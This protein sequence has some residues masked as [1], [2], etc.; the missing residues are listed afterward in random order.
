[1][2][3]SFGVAGTSASASEVAIRSAEPADAPDIAR[4]HIES[5]EHAYAPL[6]GAWP[7]VDVGKRTERWR[8]YLASEAG[9]GRCA[10]VASIG[11]GVVGFIQAGPARRADAGAAVEVFVIHVLPV[12]RGQG[13][14]NAL[15]QAACSS[16][17]GPEL[18]SM[19]VDTLAELPCCAFYEAHGGL[20]TEQRPIEYH[21]AARTH[22]TYVW[23]K[24]H[25]H[26][27]SP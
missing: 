23:P 13:V 9:P 20:R 15:W 26:G 1:L 18:M 14:G 17:R 24:D 22:V 2:G 3:Q 27:S 25:G 19:Y 11:G 21:G 7:K 4:V 16:V 8:R 6:A 12:S 10:F 5:S